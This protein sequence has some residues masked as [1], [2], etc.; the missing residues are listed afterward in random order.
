MLSQLTGNLLNITGGLIIALFALPLLLLG[1]I[2][3]PLAL[4][5]AVIMISV[6][7]TL[8]LIVAAIVGLT[9]L[10]GFF[11]YLGFSFGRDYS[12]WFIEVA[13][14]QISIMFLE[15][16][17]ITRMSLLEISVIFWVIFT[18]PSVT[19]FFLAQ[20]IPFI[21]LEVLMM[22]VSHDI[23]VTFNDIFAM[24][25]IL[26]IIFAIVV[27]LIVTVIGSSSVDDDKVVDDGTE[28]EAGN[29]TPEEDPVKHEVCY[30]STNLER[31]IC[32]DC[33][34][35]RYSAVCAEY[36]AGQFTLSSSQPPLD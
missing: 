15:L 13:Y 34:Y 5:G 12:V 21:S 1:I 22:S 14:P 3:I 2:A 16:V 29:E 25:Y 17:E 28:E 36:W 9:W 7:G 35:N 23:F 24:V 20:F 4:I 6:F 10:A 27:L 33:V 30:Y 32:V 19:G 11:G 31:N 8:G 26:I 18:I